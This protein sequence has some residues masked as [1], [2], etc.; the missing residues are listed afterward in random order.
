MIESAP[1]STWKKNV[2]LRGR[3]RRL[4]RVPL[5]PYFVYGEFLLCHS[6]LARLPLG[7]AC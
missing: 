6:F 3:H 5:A 4:E 1:F 2:G 7:G